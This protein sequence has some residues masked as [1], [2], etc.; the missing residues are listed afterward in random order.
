MT[1]QQLMDQGNQMMDETDQ[2]IE[3]SKKVSAFLERS[4]LQSRF[5]HFVTLLSIMYLS[6]HAP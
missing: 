1:N 2:I 4:F 3:R 6:T 5:Y